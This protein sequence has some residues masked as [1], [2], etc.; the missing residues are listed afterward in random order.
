M[1]TGLLVSVSL[2]L[3]KKKKQPQGKH[4]FTWILLILL[5]FLNFRDKKGR[6]ED[7]EDV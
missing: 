2:C 1:R 3:K 5:T 7:K 4:E 6:E